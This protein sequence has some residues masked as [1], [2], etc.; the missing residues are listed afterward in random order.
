MIPEATGGL[1]A[2]LSRRGP[3]CQLRLAG[4]L[5]PGPRAALSVGFDRCAV[6]RAGAAGGPSVTRVYPGSYLDVLPQFTVIQNATVHTSAA[7]ATSKVTMTNPRPAIG[8]SSTLTVVRAAPYAPAS[9][10]SPRV[11]SFER[12]VAHAL[13]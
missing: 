11:N 12:S 6:G 9:I 5:V 1:D 8:Q 7:A 10:L 4:L 13:L 2:C 3:Q